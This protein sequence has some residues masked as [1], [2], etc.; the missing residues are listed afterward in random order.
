MLVLLSACAGAALTDGLTAYY[1][2]DDADLTGNDPD[3]VTPSAHDGTTTGATT[4]VTGIL[5]EG[6]SFDGINDKLVLPSSIELGENNTFTINLWVK[7]D[8]N[9][10][11]GDVFFDSR[12]GTD[13][14]YI[15]SDDLSGS[16]GW[17]F[18]SGNSGNVETGKF[19]E[20]TWHMVTFLKKGTGTDEIELYVNGSLKDSST[21]SSSLDANM[22]LTLAVRF[23]DLSGTWWA[24][25]MDE[26]GIWNR[27]LSS[28]EISE[29]WNS[30]S[31]LA[32]PFT[33][34]NVTFSNWNLTSDGGCTA[35]NT[36]QSHVCNTTSRV[37]EVTFDTDLNTSC[38]IGV[39]DSNYTA[40]GSSR[41]CAVTGGTS[42]ECSI[43]SEDALSSGNSNLYVSCNHTEFS[44]SSSGA[45]AVNL[46][47]L[48]INFT[49]Y[50][51]VNNSNISSSSVPYTIDFNFT[52]YSPD[53]VSTCVLR[54]DGSAENTTYYTSDV[55]GSTQLTIQRTFTAEVNYTSFIYNLTCNDTE[56]SDSELKTINVLIDETLPAINISPANNTVIEGDYELLNLNTSAFDYN[57][58]SINTTVYY[59][60][61][62][63]YDNFYNNTMGGEDY[64]EYIAAFNLSAEPP[65]VYEIYTEACDG[66]TSSD[67]NFSAWDIRKKDA[68]KMID[69]GNCAVY[70]DETNMIESYDYTCENDRCSWTYNY[71]DL[72]NVRNFFLECDSYI[73]YLEDSSYQS[74][75]VSGKNWID[76][77]NVNDY[78]TSVTK[79][80]GYKYKI[81][82][83]GTDISSVTTQ[84]IGEL[85]CNNETQ[86]IENVL[87]TTLRGLII[88][89]PD[90]NI[91]SAS[92]VTIVNST[93]NL[94]QDR[95]MLFYSGGSAIKSSVPGQDATLWYRITVNGEVYMTD[96]IVT[97]SNTNDYQSFF[98]PYILANN[99]IIGENNI[100][101]EASTAGI[102]G[103]DVSDSGIAGSSFRSSS[104]YNMTIQYI[105]ESFQITNENNT[106]YFNYTFD[107]SGIVAKTLVETQHTIIN[108]GDAGVLKTCYYES[109]NDGTELSPYYSR[110]NPGADDTGSAGMNYIFDTESEN[111]NIS[112][113]CSTDTPGAVINN[114]VTGY[115]L[116]LKDT[117]NYTINTNQSSNSV[118]NIGAG[119]T[120]I[121]NISHTNKGSNFIGIIVTASISSDTSAQEGAASPFLF[122]NSSDI[123]QSNCYRGQ[124]RSLA[125][126]ADTGV[127]H[128]TMNCIAGELNTEKDFSA[129]INVSAGEQVDILNLSLT[130][131]EF[132]LI[133][134]TSGEVAP[135]PGGIISPADGSN[136]SG[137][138]VINWSEFIDPNEDPVTYN[139]TITNSTGYVI[140]ASLN[141]T[142]TNTS[143]NFSS[144]EYSQY[145]NITVYGCD[146]TGLCSSSRHEVFHFDNPPVLVI[147]VD[148][149]AD[150]DNSISLGW[151]NI[152]ENTVSAY[153]KV[154]YNG[155][156]VYS[157]AA[158]A[159][160]ITLNT[161]EHINQT[162]IYTVTYFVNESDSDQYNE[163]VNFT[164]TD[165]NPA[166]SLSALP[167]SVPLAAGSVTVI[168]NV[169]D[170][171]TGTAYIY[172]EYNSSIIWNS[173]SINGSSV[174]NTSDL[175]S[176]AGDYMVYYTVNE[177]DSDSF[178]VN[179]SFTAEIQFV[180]GNTTLIAGQCPESIAGMMGLWMFIFFG[181]VL[182]A[183]AWFT[184]TGMFGFF[185]GVI[186]MGAGFSAAACSVIAGAGLLAFAAALLGWSIFILPM[187]K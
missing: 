76:F 26:I 5:G 61:G 183:A 113:Y 134:V 120:N 173:S 114:T 124:Y 63:Q 19:L 163:S 43:I 24:G 172:I 46:Y 131:I 154:E 102:G 176:N 82:L 175:I 7:T 110:Y 60:N 108:T 106:Q 137:V 130:T 56:D 144:L 146:D 135:I 142:D 121:G 151:Y 126:T 38:R 71:K 44:A 1:T 101:L 11:F 67:I 167:A 149:A 85:N 184:K 81:S 187:Q 13:T 64:T 41:N 96:A 62:S 109:V 90:Y 182:I 18:I 118:N 170:N 92:Y 29:L 157:S 69:F 179:A 116:A 37:P 55:D 123:N 45:L 40:F 178:S 93:F 59:P 34:V 21:D 72:Q 53:N 84:S 51:P 169:S 105:N 83:S 133:D 89:V 129:Y 141:I 73:D 22:K 185:A 122:V 47:P 16:N 66:H 79:L 95:D 91:D 161:T 65:G 159:A 88:N 162:G 119:V 68:D 74:H 156:A 164:V 8:N 54:E 140:N 31:G 139:V 27:G 168:W 136:V 2:L 180:P 48:E 87:Y 111:Q 4:G 20:T 104:G 25:D 153:L 52:V 80:N 117:L 3:D 147:T 186:I 39:T 127:I 158:E 148:P 97:T 99:T 17:R 98:T 58:Y 49:A 128:Y 50:T 145:Y 57:L 15:Y 177:T 160:N 32:Y 143:F 78:D 165:Y 35:W 30:G 112:L 28:A 132:N 14:K 100:T 6:F 36:N 103:I 10:G 150:K 70:P 155:S 12:D 107:K 77:E 171:N 23:N 174:F 115:I 42:H 138:T 86:Y 33:A 125:S 166:M 94:T 9:P 181:A 75:F 152:N